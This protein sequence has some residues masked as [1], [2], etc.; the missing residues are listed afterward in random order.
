MT[1]ENFT[2]SE[3]ADILRAFNEY[4]ACLEKWI[5]REKRY[6]TTKHRNTDRKTYRSAEDE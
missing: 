2:E 3:L 4:L 5:T 1:T 6:T